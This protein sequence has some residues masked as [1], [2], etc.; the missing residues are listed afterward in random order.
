MRLAALRAPLVV[1]VVGANALVVGLAVTGCLFIP[2]WSSG[3]IAA[4]VLIAMVVHL[5]LVMIALRP[6]R[7]LELAAD[8]VWRGDFAARVK[9]SS[10]ADD[11]VLRIGSMFNL[12]LDA[13]AS[14]RV[15]LQRLA[16]NVLEHGDADRATVARELRNST[17]QQ[18]AALLYQIAAAARDVDDPA[19]RARL[20]EM[21]D[22]TEALLEQVRELSQSMHSGLLD[23]FGLEVALRRLLRARAGEVGIDGDVRVDT[24]LPEL[25]RAVAAALY[26]VAEEA[27]DNAVRHSRATHITLTVASRPAV[28][29]EVHDDGAGFDPSPIGTAI[30]GRGFA[31]MRE[32]LVVFDGTLDVDSARSRGTTVIATIPLQ[33][34]LTSNGELPA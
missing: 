30:S 34:N 26:R 22:A 14:D 21:R 19:L 29:L 11:E 28:T 18:V 7:D 12:L 17:A 6:I 15:R 25:P 20:N 27:V 31:S 3:S 16:S 8:R 2:N 24:A 32:R 1:K 10:V 5:S 9:A 23:D 13:F 33:A 4:F